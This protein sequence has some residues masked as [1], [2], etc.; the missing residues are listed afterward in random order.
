MKL[1]GLALSL[2]LAGVFLLTGCREKTMP[3]QVAQII[4]ST[5][6]SETLPATIKE[7]KERARAWD[8]MRRFYQK[9]Q[10]QPAWSDV[11]GPRPQAEQ[12]AQAVASVAATE[13]L[14]PQRY[15]SERLAGLL[16]QVKEDKSLDSPEAQ[17]RLADL[18]VEMTFVYLTLAAHTAIGRVQPETL[19][20]HWENQSR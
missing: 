15:Q 13:G 10:Y 2:A 3:P 9:R 5:V 16:S 20:I 18:D 17:R 4:R 12:L 8:E 1:R 7:Q 6:E 19:R 11:K 14:D